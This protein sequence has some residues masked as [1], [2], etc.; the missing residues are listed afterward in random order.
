MCAILK[1]DSDMTDTLDWKSIDDLGAAMR[2]GE[3]SSEEVTRASLERI[4][5]LDGK[6]NAVRVMNEAAVD[7][8]RQ[9]D[10]DRENGTATGALHGVPVM[11]KDNL[12]T[13]D[14]MPTT[15]GSL[16]LADTCASA[17][18]PVVAK[19]R[20]AGAVL[21][22]KTNLSEWANFR[23]VKSSSG[24][25]SVAGQ[26]RNPYALDR[27]P[28]GSS[29]GS[30]VA[31]AAEYCF[32]AIGTETS[33]SIVNPSH[34]NSVVGIKPTV[35]LVSRTGI[36]PIS[37]SQDT[38]GPMARSVADAAAILT[39]IVGAD[40][41]DPVTVDA[42]ANRT[43]YAACAKPDGLAG[44]RI[45]LA[46]NYCG[47][48]ERVDVLIVDSVA[49]MRDAG[50]TVVEVEMVRVED[51]RPFEIEVML[52][53]FLAG[54][55]AYL[56]GRDQHTQMR[57]LAD[58][59]EFNRENAS[60]VMPY[61]PQDLIE[62]ALTRGP[63]TSKTYLDARAECLRLTRTEGLDRTIGDNNLD[64]IV[65]PAGGLPWLIDLANGDNR[66]GTSAAPAAVSGYPNVCVPAGYIYGL[67]IGLSF[68]GKAYSEAKLIEIAAG[69]EHVTQARKEPEFLATA[70]FTLPAPP[71]LSRT[72]PKE[73]PAPW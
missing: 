42:E 41:A 55:D 29:S 67:P 54:I 21:I 2:S 19:L 20:A 58:I 46:A 23:S 36:V 16:A 5:S 59:A 32:G 60:A 73:Q 51:I 69:F 13:G 72:P 62:R 68:V 44:K 33:G 6:T 53:E 71:C 63:L 12:D 43:D 30:G 14:G 7:I 15:A 66:R 1:P 25:S 61:Y 52:T 9:R 35:G 38:A 56:A 18:S 28:G 34:M 27:T 57:S 8:A 4:R 47:A 50:A 31:V 64:A 17:D 10:R 40:P 3:V 22:G 48:D 70:D 11:V 37:H 24:W 39:A 49:A 65:S 26:V 45:G